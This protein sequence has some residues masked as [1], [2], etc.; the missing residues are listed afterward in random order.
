MVRNRIYYGI[1]PLLPQSLRLS[2]RRWLAVGTR[3][4]NQDVWPIYP[5]AERPPAGWTGWPDG[6]QFALVLTHDVESAAGLERTRALME[7]EMRLGFRSSFNFI[8]EADYRVPVQF[9]AELAANGFEVGV[10]DLHHDGKLYS[11]R[12]EFAQKAAQINRYLKEWGARGFR[13]GFMLRELNWL[14]DLEIEYDASTF[15]T[16]PFEPQPDGAHTIFPFWV[17][18]PNG[19][20]YVELP[21]TLVQDSNL[22]L[23]LKEKSIDIWKQ[24]LDWL[25]A[26]GGMA[27][28]IVHPDYINFGRGPAGRHEFPARYYEEFLSYVKEKYAGRYW[29]ALPREVAQYVRSHR[30]SDTQRKTDLPV[31]IS[32]NA[33]RTAVRTVGEEAMSSADPSFAG[34]RAAVVLYSYYPSDPRPRRAAE[35]LV[36]QGMTV[37]L[38]CLKETDDEPKEETFNGV[39][40]YRVPMRRRRGSKFGYMFQYVAF[41]A[42]SFSILTLRSLTRRYSLVHV[43]NMPDVLVFSALVPKLRGAKVIL[44]LHDPMPEL[45]VSIFNLRA[46]SFS[47]RLLKRLEKWSVRFADSVLTVNAT[48]KKIFERRSGL[49]EKITVVMNSPDETIFLDRPL[50]SSRNGEV[51]SSDSFIIMFHGSLV[52]RH[53]L[54][55]AVSALTQVQ[56]SIPQAQLRIY[57]RST[58]YLESVMKTVADRGLEKSVHYYGNKNLSQI[59]EAIEQCDVGV[60]PNR[61][62]IFTELNTPTRIFEYLSRGKPVIAPRAPGI[63]DYFGEED[64]V[65]FELGNEVDL[66]RQLERVF[67]NKDKIAETVVRGRKIYLKHTWSQEKGVFLGIV[68]RLLNGNIKDPDGNGCENLNLQVRTEQKVLEPVA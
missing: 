63:Q 52:E 20:G 2:V 34:K 66:A 50:Q 28:M 65:Y 31:T 9:R 62:N 42:T 67:K 37:D 48:C 23:I 27:M 57:G 21:Y 4:R 49:G 24:K 3:R 60:I 41:I 33:D 46:E 26:N 43:H 58:P 59:V 29:Q 32:A 5:G 36:K 39:N 8:P 38:I 10:H 15:D 16:D 40:V 17:P 12:Q 35:A 54:D 51:K 30:N 1:K 53:G 11:S 68:E 25:A 44:D 7:M 13:S 55:L 64:I 56:Q 22:F 14:H 6:K 47:V 19:R 61:R 18:G 45:M